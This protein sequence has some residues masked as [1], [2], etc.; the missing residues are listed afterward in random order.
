[1]AVLKDF[2]DM[3]WP[4]TPG[5]F[6]ALRGFAEKGQPDQRPMLRWI[7]ADDDHR[8]MKIA[9]FIIDCRDR[10]M[11]CYCVPGLVSG[12]GRAGAADVVTMTTLLIDI[13]HGDIDSIV[14]RLANDVGRPTMVAE[15]G[16]ITPD[17][18]KKRYVFWRLERDASVDQVCELNERLARG[19]GGDP[20]FGRGRAHQ[21]LRIPGSI[22]WKAG[23]VASAITFF[24][25][26]ATLDPFVANV[27]LPPLDAAARESSGTLGFARKVSMDD[28][29]MMEFK[30]GGTDI[31]RFEAMTRMIGTLVSSINDLDNREEVEREFGYFRTWA[32][33]K[34]ENV[35][36]DYDLRQHWY[37]L[38]ARERNKRSGRA[39]FRP[40]F[41]QYRRTNFI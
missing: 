9:R 23:P 7:E 41:R 20:A 27:R 11:A 25:G 19:F 28:L 16:G 39:G 36:R 21:P 22:H 34:I 8:V 6:I 24:D 26:T 13:D 3:V 5:A 1:M 18:H 15:S 40:K 35:E 33:R 14:R 10:Q 12:Y 2:V 37:R 29:P 4:K 17:G 38:L 31:T 32:V 30:H